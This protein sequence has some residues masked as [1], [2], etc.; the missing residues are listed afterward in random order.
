VPRRPRA[1]PWACDLSAHAVACP[2]LSRSMRPRRCECSARSDEACNGKR[3]SVFVLTILTRLAPRDARLSS[4]VRKARRCPSRCARF[5]RSGADRRPVF[6][7]SSSCWRVC[8]RADGGRSGARRSAEQEQ[9]VEIAIALVGAW[10]ERVS[11]NAGHPPCWRRELRQN[12]GLVQRRTLSSGALLRRCGCAQRRVGREQ[13]CRLLGAAA[14]R[15]APTPSAGRRE[16]Q[17]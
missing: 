7:V 16:D 10:S 9:Q 8:W 3:R 11:E 15:R 5:R 4:H 12:L 13:E 17:K 2:G 6:L 1:A 14:T